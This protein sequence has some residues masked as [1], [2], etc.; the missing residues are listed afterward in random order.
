MNITKN[1]TIF[2]LIPA[3]ISNTNKINYPELLEKLA[4]KVKSSKFVIDKNEVVAIIRD[5]ADEAGTTL[6]V[7]AKIESVNYF[8][9][10]GNIRL[11]MRQTFE[12]EDII[13]LDWSYS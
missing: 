11:I 4:E 10:M 13:L 8:K 2:V 5:M 6:A 7:K 3:K 1:K 9:C 12:D